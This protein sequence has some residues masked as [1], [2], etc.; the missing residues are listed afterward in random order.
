[1]SLRSW[2]APHLGVSSLGETEGIHTFL[3][4]DQ[5]QYDIL[6]D[7]NTLSRYKLVI[8]GDDRALSD[9]EADTLR[10]YVRGGGRLLV[11]GLTGLY[12]ER[13]KKR[14]DFALA[15]V[16][17]VSYVDTNR[18]PDYYSDQAP[19]GLLKGEAFKVEPHGAKTLTYFLNPETIWTK[20]TTVLWQDP[21]PDPA[22]RYPLVTLNR[23]GNG[24]CIYIAVSIGNTIFLNVRQSGYLD[25]YAVKLLREALRTLEIQPSVITTTMGTE[26]VLNKHKGGHVL[27]LINHLAGPPLWLSD[28]DHGEVRGV[29]VAIRKSKIGN[30][31]KAMEI[32]TGKVIPLRQEGEWI[33]FDAPPYQVSTAILLQGSG[34]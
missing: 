17:G 33:K 3:L 6:K 27:H 15:E 11:T 30:P 26:V 14:S 13:G 7:L 5:W 22:Q 10:N 19:P 28:S 2:D 25:T 23:F 4:R 12:D 9:R 8:V 24:Q 31:T 29:E 1:L 34:E 16:L 20:G 18:Y 32:V 21:P